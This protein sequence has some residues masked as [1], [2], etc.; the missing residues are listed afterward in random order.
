[1]ELDQLEGVLKSLGQPGFRAKQVFGWMH[2]GVESFDEMS[3]LPKTLRENLKERCDLEVLEKRNIQISRKDG[4]RKYLFALE[5]GQFIESVLMKYEYGNTVCISSQ[6]GC[7]MGCAF[8]ASHEGGLV[9]NLTP[10]E[11]L[12]QILRIQRDLGEKI[13]HIVV[14]GVGEPFDNYENLMAFLRNVHDEAGLNLSYRNIT[15]ST[16]GILPRMR[17]FAEEMPQV[18]L[19]VSLHAAEDSLRSRMMPINRKYPLKELISACRDYVNMTNKRITFEYILI[20]G[21]N[22]GPE[23]AEQLARLLKGL[24]CHV[25]L[26]PYNGVYGKAWKGSSR[27]TGALFRDRLGDKGIPATIRRELGGDIDG[28]C[29]Q[30]RSR[31]IRDEGK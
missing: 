16:C 23:Q 27:K 22:D 4:T 5:D 13:N 8:C 9:R 7:R 15:V 1:M 21:V 25:N 30:L 17:A 6:A 24:L 14:M 20:E 10:G 3:N 31:K 26:I 28:A 29:G 18:T 11:M 12:D 2:R 19:A